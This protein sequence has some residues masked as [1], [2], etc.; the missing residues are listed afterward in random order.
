M[1][2]RVDASLRAHRFR[3]ALMVSLGGLALLLAVI[4]IYGV[5]AH[6]VIRRTR[7]IGIRMALGEASLDVQRRVVTDAMRVASIGI[8]LGVVLAL[9]AG[10]WLTVFLVGVSPRDPAMLVGSALGLAAVVCCAAFGP[11][12]RAARVD[13][14]TAL[15][16]E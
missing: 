6:T 1:E 15:R 3:A 10:K 12:R 14:V 13:P 4:G 11:A 16:A 5:V 2:Q 7:E 9:L 8:A